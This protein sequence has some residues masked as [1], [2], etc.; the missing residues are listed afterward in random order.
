MPRPCAGVLHARLYKAS[1]RTPLVLNAP[2]LCRGAS[3]SSL[4]GQ[5]PH[6]SCFECPGL[7]PGCFTLVSTRPV[8]AL[9]LF[10]MPRPCA[11]VLHARLYKASART[12]LVLDAPA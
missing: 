9:L 3:R 1:A 6:S 12:P 10:W 8:P 7:V 4:Q 11:G 2:A 5:C